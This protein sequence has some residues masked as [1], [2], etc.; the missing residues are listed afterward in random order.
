[1]G[2]D[3][4]GTVRNWSQL[5][6]Q[7]LLPSITEAGGKVIGGAGDS[8]LAEFPSATAA[9]T[10]ALSVQK[11]IRLQSA[12][13]GSMQVRIG[14]NVDDV[15]DDGETLQSDGV[16]IASRIH[17]LAAPGEIVTTQV[18][19]ELVR[20]RINATFRDLGAPPLKNIDRPVHVYAVEEQTGS[21]EVGRPHASWSSRP[22]LAV[23]PFRDLAASEVDRYFGEGI[24]EDIITGVSRS[25][26]MFVIAR[27]STLHYADGS[28]CPKEIANALGVRYLLTGSIRRRADKLRINAELMDVDRSR[29]VW[30]E[31]FDGSAQ[32]LFEFQDQI[33]A[34]IVAALEPRV[35]GAEV[36]SLGTRPTESLDAYDCVLRAL[37]VLYRFDRESYAEAISL[38][39]RAV[40]LD[41]GYA[42]A[43]AYLAWALNFWIGE[44]HSKEN[45][46][47]DKERAVLAAR[48]AVD[49]DPEDAFCLAVRAHIFGFLEGSP[50]DALDLLDQALA[51]NENLPLAWALSAANYAYLGAGDEARDRLLN[52]WRLAPH[53]PLN[54]F[55]WAAGGLAEFVMQRYDE[56]I[57]LL[58]KSYQAKPRFVAC[59]RTL[60]PALALKGD[61]ELALR[62]GREL[63]AV[64]PGFSISRFMS[65]YPLKHPD[66][67]ERLVLGLSIAGLP[68]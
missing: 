65:S 45:K 54:F 40:S 8:L 60:A 53:D 46:E 34:N 59:L 37:S 41:S 51:L 13:A 31:R 49:L 55:F 44:G 47:A 38:L 24:T 33:A 6:E 58:Q 67:R 42:Q 11:A 35:L 52:V 7:L 56:A 68:K 32:N 18:T 64:E 66:A 1:M 25:R 26:A 43:H 9:V 50:A 30:A 3:A 29:T 10:W 17:Q 27:T 22:T 23:L 5:R 39:E 4:M 15:V 62:I 2:D 21:R 36:A 14:V 48:R 20:G 28:R 16:N 12:T 61:T 57:A 19:R 63:M